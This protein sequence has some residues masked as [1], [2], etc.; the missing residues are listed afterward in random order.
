MSPSRVRSLACFLTFAVSLLA[1]AQTLA[2]YVGCS[3]DG[4]TGPYAAAKRSPK[5]VNL[6]QA[7]ADQ[8]AWYDDNG[9]A[10]HFGTLGRR[11]WNCFATIGS[12]GWTLYVAPEPLDSAKLLQHKNWKGLNGQPFNIPAPTHTLWRRPLRGRIPRRGSSHGVRWD[13]AKG[14]PNILP[15]SGTAR[16]I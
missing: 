4:Q 1:C 11:G 13:C 9:D 16:T 5:P 14:V 2:P 8:L 6:S 3:G 15:H 10:G 7:I 12:N